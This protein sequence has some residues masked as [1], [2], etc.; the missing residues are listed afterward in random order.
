MTALLSYEGQ[1]VIAR[2][3]RV[4]A[5]QVA[6]DQFT[7]RYMQG[8]SRVRPLNR[9]IATAI[10]NVAGCMVRFNN[11]PMRCAEASNSRASSAAVR[12]LATNSTNC[13]LN[14]NGYGG[15]NFLFSSFISDSFNYIIKVFV[16]TG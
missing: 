12:P 1:L 8:E 5:Q 14:S 3:V 11:T 16:K 7:V 6:G 4:L 9:A 2:R 15:L 10:N 13:C